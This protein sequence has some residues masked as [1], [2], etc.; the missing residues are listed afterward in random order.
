MEGGREE[1]RGRI[2]GIGDTAMMNV[3]DSESEGSTHSTSV[4]TK[5]YPS[6]DLD[7]LFENN[8]ICYDPKKELRENQLCPNCAFRV[9]IGAI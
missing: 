3:A 2:N 4:L 9:D 6:F 5:V 7:H 1:S 8:P